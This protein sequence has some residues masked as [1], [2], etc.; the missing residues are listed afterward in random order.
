LLLLAAAFVVTFFGAQ[1]LEELSMTSSQ[2]ENEVKSLRREA[3]PDVGEMSR[4]PE[5]HAVTKQPHHQ[6][7]L[8][9][10]SAKVTY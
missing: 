7:P 8:D 3:Y 4:Q 2:L 9:S 6:Q 5:R 10:V 1:R